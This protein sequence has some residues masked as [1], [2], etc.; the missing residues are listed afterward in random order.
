MRIAGK[1]TARQETRILSPC[2]F[3]G[4]NTQSTTGRFGATRL[5]TELR[6]DVFRAER[7]EAPPGDAE[8]G[9]TL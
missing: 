4:E 9:A 5:V 2:F 8:G 6:L 7:S 1:M 3:N